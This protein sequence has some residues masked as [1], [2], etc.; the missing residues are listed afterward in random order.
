MNK[1]SPKNRS[2]SAHGRKFFLVRWIAAASAF[3]IA[4]A[5]FT[6]AL[7]NIYEFAVGILPRN[8]SVEF[9]YLD[10]KANPWRAEIK[11]ESFVIASKDSIG[12]TQKVQSLQYLT[13]DRSPWEAIIKNGQFI[14]M[15]QGDFR[16]QHP[17]AVLN[18]LDWNG[19]RQQTS[20][21]PN[22]GKRK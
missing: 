16:N 4:V 15:P 9:Y 5:A 11:D 10:W 21:V 12:T 22:V 13:W 6:G 2:A 14:H 3:V 1:H 7:K 18:Y 20:M 8:R 19:A 17:D